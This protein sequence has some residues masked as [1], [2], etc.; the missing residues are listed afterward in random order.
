[1]SSNDTKETKSE[2]EG[3]EEIHS[4]SAGFGLGSVHSDEST[5]PNSCSLAF[6]FPPAYH[7]LHVSTFILQTEYRQICLDLITALNM[8]IESLSRLH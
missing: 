8:L 4:S 2:N 7:F 5:Q 3:D 1:M 6:P